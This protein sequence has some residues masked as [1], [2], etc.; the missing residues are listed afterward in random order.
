MLS[1]EKPLHVTRPESWPEMLTVA[2][3]NACLVYPL[4]RTFQM[5]KRADNASIRQ[6]TAL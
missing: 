2:I 5:G 4:P 6:L 3:V 1:W